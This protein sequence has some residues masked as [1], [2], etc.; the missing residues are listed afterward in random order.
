M[1]GGRFQTKQRRFYGFVPYSF[2][3]GFYLTLY[4]VNVL[5][6]FMQFNRVRFQWIWR[7]VSAVGG[8]GLLC[9]L[10]VVD[11][12][13][14][15][16]AAE[17]FHQRAISAY[18]A[19]NI[20]DA[21]LLLA[22]AL[23]EDDR[24]IPAY[25]ARGYILRYERDYQAAVNDFSKVIELDSSRHEAWFRRGIE[26]FNLGE[27]EKSVA[28][29]EQYIEFRPE[30]KPFLWQL[31]IAYYYTGQHQEGRD[32]F[33]SHQKVNSHDVENAVWHFLCVAKLDGFETARK[34]LIDLDGDTR[35]P[36]MQVYALFKGHGTEE[37]VLTAAHA[38]A[39]EEDVLIR[40][41]FY[42]HLYL[43]LYHEAKGDVDKS[44]DYM[45]RAAQHFKSNG[46]MGEVA[47]VHRDW[48]KNK[49]R[50]QATPHSPVVTD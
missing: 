44:Y 9:L 19:G 10:M 31:G 18:T 43:G 47:R 50:R 27:F 42:A 21:K 29:F 28:D 12:G 46:Y 16:L 14:D 3:N 13:A 37:H 41:S 8:G 26:Y 35:I 15:Q 30:Q 36:M 23:K 38:G 49:K 33:E 48:L 45:R 22:D 34:A 5:V 17:R 1:G 24:Y 40:Q 6:G 2:A 32:L 11:G 4:A 7:V 39:P 20:D 25:L